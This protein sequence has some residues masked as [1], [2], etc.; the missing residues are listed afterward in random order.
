MPKREKEIMIK[1]LQMDQLEARG[2]EYLVEQELE[3]VSSKPLDLAIELRKIKN[4][5]E[6]EL[7]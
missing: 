1:K 5:T 7:E 2:T 4:P 6:S 3:K